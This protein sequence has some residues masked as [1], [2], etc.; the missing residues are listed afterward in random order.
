MTRFPLTYLHLYGCFS[1]QDG[2]HLGHLNSCGIMQQVHGH[3]VQYSL[4][5]YEKETGKISK[6]AS[7]S[8]RCVW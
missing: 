8:G 7:D 1:R 4:L 3:T 2:E 5:S 6:L